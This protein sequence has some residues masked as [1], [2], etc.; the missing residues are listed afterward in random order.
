MHIFED[1]YMV[2]IINITRGRF[3]CTPLSLNSL[4]LKK[5][6]TKKIIK[7]GLK[8]FNGAKVRIKMTPIHPF[9]LSCTIVIFEGFQS[10]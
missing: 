7:N 3:G 2:D 5:R 10:I 9:D 1:K 4:K 8:D 6:S